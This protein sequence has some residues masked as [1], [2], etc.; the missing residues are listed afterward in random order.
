MTQQIVIERHINVKWKNITKDIN[1]F[2][3]S[4]LQTIFDEDENKNYYVIDFSDLKIMDSIITSNND[5]ILHIQCLAN[6]FYPKKNEILS[7]S[8]LEIDKK[9]NLIVFSNFCKGFKVFVRHSDLS[10]KIG[11][12]KTVVLEALKNRKQDVIA[13]GHILEDPI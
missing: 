3:K 1:Q 4:Y 7:M 10:L 5:L 11:Q 6:V 9:N 2:L 12:T 8:I 13:I